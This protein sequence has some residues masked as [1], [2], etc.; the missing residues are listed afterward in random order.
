M[1]IHHTITEQQF[2]NKYYAV[3]W[4]YRYQH[5]IVGVRGKAETEY[6][7]STMLRI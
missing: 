7:P 5:T 2:V 6:I 4:C 3:T 1:H